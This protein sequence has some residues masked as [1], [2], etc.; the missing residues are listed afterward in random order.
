MWS[1]LGQILIFMTAALAIGMATGVA[2]ARSRSQ[3]A[4]LNDADTEVID[5]SISTLEDAVD[6]EAM[7]IEQLE[8]AHDDLRAHGVELEDAN[9]E[10]MYL[11]EELHEVR[12]MAPQEK[13]LRSI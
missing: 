8:R 4:A 10:I 1:L 2:L 13:K 12:Y 6:R 5:D 9:A 3:S 11:L 7:L